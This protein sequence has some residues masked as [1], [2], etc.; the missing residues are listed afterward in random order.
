MSDVVGTQNTGE[1]EDSCENVPLYSQRN[2]NLDWRSNW[3][4]LSR[5]TDNAKLL[6]YRDIA[7]DRKRDLIRRRGR[8]S[9][10]KAG[11]DP[12]GA[13]SP[14]YSLG[15]RNIGGR[16][17][18]IAIDPTN[19]DVIYVGTAAGG[20][21]KTLDGGQTWE[22]LWDTQETVAIGAIAVSVS[23]ADTIYAGTGEWTPGWSG[24]YGGAGFYV[25]TDAGATWSKR[26]AVESRYI[27][28]LVVDP[29]NDQ[30]IWIC[31]DQ[32][33]ER[34]T[35]GG[36]T[37][38]NL[39]RATVT[40][41]VLDP[42]NPNTV[43]IAVRYD[44][45]Y[46]S[47]DSGDTFTLLPGSPTGATVEFP[48]M[49]IGRSGTHANNFIVIMMAS[50]IQSSIDGGN[51]FNVVPGTHGGNYPGWCDLVGAAPDDED[52]LFWG[53]ISLDR[54]AN[55]G[56][57]WTSLPVHADQHGV[58]FAPSNSNI[59][60]FV[61]DGGV[62]RSNDKGATVQKVSTYIPEQPCKDGIVFGRR[63]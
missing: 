61:N 46:K 34:S 28:Q 13:G 17:K 22:A 47:T 60:Y 12:A 25:S 45:F 40:D 58:A 49:A 50:V 24:N 1:G 30:R 9:G 2:K 6:K 4:K 19:P 41:V 27:G 63:S 26:P 56:T 35:D 18:S 48:Q 38:T 5:S 36:L 42:L 7:Y 55:G 53:G 59:V 14:W 33:L 21:W 29:T 37:W 44:G 52:V 15:P 57:N 10:N 62:Y 51:N 20:V 54:T 8:R 23:S 31:G 43:F 16:C 3:F 39:R 32:G 11:Y